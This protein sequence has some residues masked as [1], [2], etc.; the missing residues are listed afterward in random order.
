MTVG[1]LIAVA[2]L[3]VA[4][5]WVVAPLLRPDAAAVERT[6]ATLSLAREL[7]S[8]REQLLASL[9]DLEDDRATG[10][11]DEADYTSMRAHLEAEAVAIMRK[12][13]DVEATHDREVEAERRALRP[14]PHPSAETPRQE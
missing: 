6:S 14:L 5:G 13:D 12:L 4:V 10:K 3:A 8:R 11:L 7:E 9:R 2:L 1:T